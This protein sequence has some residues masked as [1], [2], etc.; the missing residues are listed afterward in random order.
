[1]YLSAFSLSSFLNLGHFHR[2][3]VVPYFNCDPLKTNDIN[4]LFIVLF[5]IY[6][7]CL[8]LCLSDLLLIFRYL[9][10]VYMCLVCFSMIPRYAFGRFSNTL[11]QIFL[12]L[13]FIVCCIPVIH[14]LH[15]LQSCLEIFR[16][17]IFSL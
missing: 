13:H 3:T 5:I 11:S 12:L 14:I 8:M 1:M 9:L 4:L 7:T 15:T 17:P 16:R 2:C 10:T 6:L